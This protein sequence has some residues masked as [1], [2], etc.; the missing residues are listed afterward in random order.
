MKR[1]FYNENLERFLRRSA[2]EV[3]MKPSEEVWKGIS[4]HLN[5]KK[6]RFGLFISFGLLISTALGYY[7]IDQSTRSGSTPALSSIQT[8]RETQSKKQTSSVAQHQQL[9]SLPAQLANA[10]R[11]NPTF[12][13]HSTPSTNRRNT[14]KESAAALVDELSLPMS[15]DHHPNGEP[16]HFSGTI[17]DSDPLQEAKSSADPEDNKPSAQATY[18]YTIESVTNAYHPLQKRKRLGFQFY[19]TPTVSYRKLTENEH[20][21]KA[22]G[23]NV[24]YLSRSFYGVNDAVTHRPDFG[25]EMG[26]TS[27]YALNKTLKLRAG[28]QFNVSRYAIKAYNSNTQMA[29]IVLNNTRADSVSA[30]T[31]YSNQSGYKEDWLQNF[32]V[33]FSA[34]VGL[35]MQLGNRGNTRFGVAGTV[36]P[37]YVLGDRA[38][39]ISTDYKNYAEVPSLIRKW[40]VNTSFE[41][42]VAYST[43]HLNWQVGPQIRYQLLSSYLDKYPVKENLF[44]FGLR[45]GV[46]LRKK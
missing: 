18:P 17:I 24:S 44:D 28:L 30:P 37:T 8:A 4:N 21:L 6:R 26:F 43:G 5:R 27:K 11:S 41:A 20:Y 13:L 31:V 34:P 1:D 35:E 36:Q 16:G 39:M 32:Y 23:N 10:A 38:Y 33:Q 7:I 22:N 19:F 2:E 15:A 40:N 46:S 9:S 12:A 3:R 25:F 42:F 29:T 14:I 45:V